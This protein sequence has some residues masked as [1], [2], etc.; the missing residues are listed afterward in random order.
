MKE[1]EVFE[2]AYIKNELPDFFKGSKDY[3]IYPKDAANFMEPQKPGTGNLM[4]Y[5]FKFC[6]I[7]YC[8]DYPEK[9]IGNKIIEVL[10]EMV[11]SRD[12]SDFYAGVKATTTILRNNFEKDLRVSPENF[13]KLLVDMKN[14]IEKN[15]NFLQ[16]TINY[17]GRITFYEEFSRMNNSL[18]EGK[19]IL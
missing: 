4:F 9:D 15:K 12:I 16:S 2:K 5:A 11:L 19:H 10:N 3:M 8:E 14:A 6:I 13:E 1:R 7:P 17:F 18:E